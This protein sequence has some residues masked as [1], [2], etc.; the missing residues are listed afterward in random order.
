VLIAARGKQGRRHEAGDSVWLE[1]TDA[2]ALRLIA[3]LA[4][5]VSS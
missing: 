4:A 2:E 5:A 3:R 1:M